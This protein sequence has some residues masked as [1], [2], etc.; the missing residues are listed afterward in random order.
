MP[1]AIGLQ[2]DQ[3]KNVTGSS[4]Q[5]V[6]WHLACTDLWYKL[7]WSDAWAE[8][9][10][11]VFQYPE[12]NMGMRSNQ[13]RYLFSI[14]IL[15]SVDFFAFCFTSGSSLIVSI[16]YFVEYWQPFLHILSFFLVISPEL[17]YDIWVVDA[18]FQINWSHDLVLDLGSRSR[19]VAGYC[20]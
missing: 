5:P 19:A 15:P 2:P 16:W 8:K 17:K 6:K 1:L 13:L 3:L 4:Y 14:L 20:V 11:L 10:I 7:T 9:A 18:G 12:T